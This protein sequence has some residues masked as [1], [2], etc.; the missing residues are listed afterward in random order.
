ML[1]VYVTLFPQND[2]EIE[3]QVLCFNVCLAFHDG[4]AISVVLGFFNKI[5]LNCIKMY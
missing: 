5:V 3:V 1:S 2:L 4:D